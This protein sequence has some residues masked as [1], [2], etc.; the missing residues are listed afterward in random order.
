MKHETDNLYVDMANFI[1]HGGR[2]ERRSV[3]SFSVESDQAAL[4][5]LM[6]NKLQNSHTPPTGKTAADLNLQ[7]KERGLQDNPE[8]YNQPGQNKTSSNL[9]AIV[10]TKSGTYY[11]FH[12]DINRQITS[13]LVKEN[14]IED[15]FNTSFS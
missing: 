9:C 11:K 15:S 3:C 13:K 2:N 12:V 5:K 6:N 14:L 10:V 1:Q 8:M 7:E 4:V